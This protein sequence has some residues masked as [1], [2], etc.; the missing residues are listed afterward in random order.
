MPYN[1]CLTVAGV[2]FRIESDISLYE[3]EEFL[4]FF[5]EHEDADVCA[6][7]KKV[8][9]LRA[10]PANAVRVERLYSVERDGDTWRRYF[11]ETPDRADCYAAAS[12]DTSRGLVEVEYLERGEQFVC[13]VK[14]SFYHIGFESFLLQR[15]MLVLHASAVDTSV[16]GLLF[17][18]PSGIG[19]STQEKLWCTLD[20]ARRINGDRPI[21]SLD[22]GAVTAYG[23]PY[24]G[25]S[26]VHVNESAT[27]RAV[28]FLKKSAE[29]SCRRL[30]PSE[31]FRAMWPM[32]TVHSFD[33]DFVDAASA[34]CVDLA[35]SLA[36]Y[37]L[38]CTP[39]ERA[40]E[41]VRNILSRKD[42]V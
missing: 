17:S 42:K 10:V 38:S 14:N 33:A 34:L 3:N 16:G 20:G 7:F 6:R 9:A 5:T 32:M 41:L 12:C 18:G 28:F 39:D 11:H 27:V 13:E 1:R 8:A 37:E 4:P 24:A 31:A 35:S 21:I 29:C 40:L 25:S 26:K 23:S 15:G 19:K 30:T 2:T 22:N 36:A